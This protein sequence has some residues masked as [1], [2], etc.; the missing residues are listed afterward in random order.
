MSMNNRIS[1]R[2]ITAFTSG[3]LLLVFL[4]GCKYLHIDVANISHPPEVGSLNLLAETF[5]L[6]NVGYEN[7]E[8]FISGNASAFT[9]INEFSVKGKWLAE[10]TEQAQ[11]KTR[12]VVHRPVDPAD[13]SGTVMVEWMNVTAGFDVPFSLAAGHN[14]IY[15]SGHIWVGVTA[16]KVGIDGSVN[17]LAP[18]HLKAVNANRY[19]ELNH[20]GDSFS[21]DIFSQ[22]AGVLRN[23]QEIDVLAGMQA[24]HLLAMGQSQSANRLTTYVNAIQPLYNAYDG[25]ILHSRTINSSSL[26][27]SPQP[28]VQTPPAPQIRKDVNVPVMTFQTETDVTG[29]GYVAAR[30]DDSKHFILWEVAGTGHIDNYMVGF[31]RSDSAGAAEFAEVAE[32]S[33]VF[34][35][36][37]CDQPINAGPVHFVFQSALR[38]VN[39]WIVG[40]HRPLAAERLNLV[41]ASTYAL[42]TNG[43]ATGGVRTPYVDAP[44]AILTGKFNTGDAFCSLVGT[45]ELFDASLMASLYTDEAGFVAAV[46][47]TTQNAV[48][49]GFII[50]QDGEAIIQWAPQQWQAQQ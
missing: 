37:N 22:V 46:I 30:Q 21:Y 48:N 23:P 36:V 47:N 20:P 39:T 38:A 24:K 13:F 16:Q 35:L 15:R 28:D 18:L 14:E 3:F 25:F 45:T 43:N 6:A 50:E 11:Y 5:D 4:S 33:S 2:T 27:Q 9:N 34:G 40:G 1:L 19:T 8:Y 29:L 26:S 10:P 31:G 17:G 42:D 12:I 32:V 41:S 49:A 7:S 44:S